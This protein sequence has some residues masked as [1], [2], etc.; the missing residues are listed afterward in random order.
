MDAILPGYASDPRRYDIG[1]HDRTRTTCERPRSRLTSSGEPPT[2]VPPRA[3]PLRSAPLP[4]GS[5]PLPARRCA[6]R[7]VAEHG[8]DPP[9]LP[10]KHDLAR[11]GA[12]PHS[13]LAVRMIA[14]GEPNPLKPRPPVFA[15]CSSHGSPRRAP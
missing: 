6:S 14:D 5:R 12:V 9:V 13:R 3:A 4:P 15:M 1:P 8:V 2:T 10:D 11:V 7:P